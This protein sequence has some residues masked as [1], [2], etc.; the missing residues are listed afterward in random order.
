M[1]TPEDQPQPLPEEALPAPPDRDHLW[2]TAALQGEL[3]KLASLPEGENINKAD[4]AF[5]ASLV[6]VA[7]II[8]GSGR[9][10]VSPSEALEAVKDACNSYPWLK[11]KEI[12]RQWKNAYNFADPRYRRD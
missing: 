5:Y 6:K 10:Y 12:E 11:E 4:S 2:A 7:A 8:K 1:S 3:E 9:A